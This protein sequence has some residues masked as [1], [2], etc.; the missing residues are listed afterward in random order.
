MNGFTS[1]KTPGEFLSEVRVGTH[2]ID[3]QITELDGL[4]KAKEAELSAMK[5]QRDALQSHLETLLQVE[6]I[7]A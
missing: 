3:D 6:D 4:M 7:W 2:E 5:R 1:G